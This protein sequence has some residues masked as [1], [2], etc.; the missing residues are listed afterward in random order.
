MNVREW[1]LPVYTLLVELAAGALLAIWLI[2]AFS[3][4]R[5]GPEET[6]RLTVSPL[7]V[8]FSTILVAIIGSHFH[9]SKP[10]LS[11]LSVLNFR[12][13]WLS[14]EVVFTALFFL[15]VGWLVYLL[16]GRRGS[17]WMDG[18]GWGTILVGFGTVYCMGQIYLLPSQ[19]A[20]N[21]PLT[22][23]SFFGSAMLLG[24]MATSS[25]LTLDLKFTEIR[26]PSISTARLEIV[27]RALGPL[28]LAAVLAAGLTLSIDLAKIAHLQ[29]G[30][31]AAQTSL[32][33]WLGLYQPLV[34]VRV[35][36]LCAGAGWLALAVYRMQRTGR[37]VLD[38][39][40]P[41]Y[42]ACLLVMIAEIL[43][44]FLFYAAHVRA[45]I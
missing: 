6:D 5:F 24:T 41:A 43:G 27:R 25:L 20:W 15:L 17:R 38:L 12:S 7:L 13:S 16:L 40:A 32:S 8:I 36:L 14:R 4:P 34:W 30:S 31:P 22:V 35:G 2:R 11:F 10:A 29:E 33:L 42:L 19:E 18:L 1:A 39:I 3:R 45:G 21:H 9:L 26:G 28:A 44:R 37:P 23:A